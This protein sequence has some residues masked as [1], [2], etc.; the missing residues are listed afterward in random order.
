MRL[1]PKSRCGRESPDEQTDK[2]N[3]RSDHRHLPAGATSLWLEVAISERIIVN[4][5]TAKRMLH[6]LQ[7]TV[8]RHEQAFGLLET[9]M[10]KRIRPGFVSQQG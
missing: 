6:A 3:S 7:L 9:D 10:Q 1:L 8:Q 2:K 4:Y 5:Y